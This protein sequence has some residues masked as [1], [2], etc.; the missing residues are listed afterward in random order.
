MNYRMILH[1]STMDCLTNY[2]SPRGCL[3]YHLSH[4]KHQLRYP[5]YLIVRCLHHHRLGY[6]M[7]RMTDYLMNCLTKKMSLMSYSTKRTSYLSYLMKSMNYYSKMSL[8]SCSTK[9]L[10]NRLMTR[11][12][13]CPMI[14]HYLTMGRP[15]NYRPPRG[16]L[17]Y[18]LNRPMMELEL[19]DSLLL[20]VPSLLQPDAQ[21][22]RHRWTAYGFPD[23][24]VSVAVA[25]HPA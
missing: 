19:V 25:R 6:V 3:E 2:H 11:K 14:L 4:P 16:C 20:P 21:I 15:T 13:N 9:S 12:M 23:I 17:E 8:T 10:L 7:K 18:H 22:A 1:Y 24:P 5:N